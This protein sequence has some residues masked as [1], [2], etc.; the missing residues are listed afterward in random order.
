MCMQPGGFGIEAKGGPIAYA[1]FV[2]DHS[3]HSK[4]HPGLD[5]NANSDT[6]EYTHLSSLTRKVHDPTENAFLSKNIA[7]KEN[8][9][10]MAKPSPDPKPWRTADVNLVNRSLRARQVEDDRRAKSWIADR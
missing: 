8:G 1:W 2:W 7:A 9:S 5:M 6:S 3:A 10:K 4:E